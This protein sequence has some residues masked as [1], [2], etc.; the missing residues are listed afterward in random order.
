MSL[1]RTDSWWLMMPTSLL[2]LPSPVCHFPLWSLSP[3]SPTLPH[4]TAPPPPQ[5][6]PRGLGVQEIL[7]SLHKGLCSWLPDL[8]SVKTVSLEYALK[9]PS[10]L[11]GV[12]HLVLQLLGQGGLAFVAWRL[13]FSLGKCLDLLGSTQAVSEPVGYQGCTGSSIPHERC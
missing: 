12:C 6:G 5:P 7:L 3:P 4:P 8:K 9:F 10:L 13:R 2:R 1:G 11:R